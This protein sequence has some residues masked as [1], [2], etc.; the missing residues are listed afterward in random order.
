MQPGS[1]RFRQV[2]GRRV[3]LAEKARF[4]RDDRVDFREFRKD[5]WVE[6]AVKNQV[7]VNNELRMV[8]F[9]Y[10]WWD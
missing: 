2:F 4:F 9:A 1:D 6:F 10:P 5:R 8:T 7:V 3:Q